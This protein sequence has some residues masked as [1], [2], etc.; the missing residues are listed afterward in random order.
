MRTDL[1]SDDVIPTILAELPTNSCSAEYRDHY[2]KVSVRLFNPDGSTMLTTE[3]MPIRHL[4][5]RSLLASRISYWK[6]LLDKRWPHGLT[7]GATEA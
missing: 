5:Q 7:A 2:D 6:S 1:R 3:D 4:R